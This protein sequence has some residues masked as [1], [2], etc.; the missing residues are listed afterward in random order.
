MKSRIKHRLF[1]LLD[2]KE[3]NGTSEK[4]L[5]Y[6][7]LFMIISNVIAVIVEPSVNSRA[8]IR[9]LRIFELFSMVVFTIEYLLRLW[10]SDAYYPEKRPFLARLR[11]TFSGMA[12]I[13]LLS[14]LPFY[15]PFF[16]PVDLRVLRSLRLFRLI[17]LF[18]ANRYVKSLNF[19]IS[20]IKHK[21]S[22]LISSIVIVLVLMLISATIMFNFEHDA[23]PEAFQNMFDAL[24][25]AIATLTTVGY[26]DIYP[27]TWVGK[28]F[29]GIIA[30][31]GI[32]IVAI[33]TGI[34]ASGFTE[35]MDH[36]KGSKKEALVC[37]H[38]GKPFHP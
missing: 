13:D 8:G 35:L 27:V 32:G 26:G 6:F 15:L 33:P 12:L 36:S 1:E 22:E 19:V 28:L 17:R 31:L 16:L 24:W 9:F 34:I 11:Y 10:V 21:A 23:Q 5:N 18:K 30:L 37:P 2:P 25:W 14:I 38:C 20:V 4:L 29:A 7:L 3:I